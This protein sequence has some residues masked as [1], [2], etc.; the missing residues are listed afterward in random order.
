MRDWLSRFLPKKWRKTSPVIP[1]I[2][3]TGPIGLGGSPL[4][5][6]LSLATIAGPLEKAFSHKQ[7]PAVAIS[8]NSPGGSPVQ[9]RL[10]FERIR[11]LAEE[12]EKDVFVFVEDVAASGG[13]MIA[14]AGDEIIADPSSVVGSIG[15][16]SAGFGFVD[17]IAKLGVERR[18]Y[19]SGT[20][21]AVL[22]PFRPENEGDIEHLKALQSEVHEIF[23]EMV[24]L[25]RGEVLAD[26]EDLFS[27][28]FWSG[29]SGLQLGLV[30]RLGDMRS[31]LKEKFG[32]DVK[33]KL[34]EASK[35]FFAR[36][37]VGQMTGL[38]NSDTMARDL[39]AVAEERALWQRYGF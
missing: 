37:L 15:V 31:V 20:R 23:I 1:V 27:G 25:R 34:V 32:K 22:D 19:T 7:A 8:I 2:R 11:Q 14:L 33:L 4:K 17:A 30:D 3:M 29:K 9:S 5:S 36:R 21:K 12:K 10:I 26:D 13:Y 6:G 39:V 18:V 35:P 16:V 28:L 38:P 24:K